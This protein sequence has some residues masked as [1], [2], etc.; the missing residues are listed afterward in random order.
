MSDER[1]FPVSKERVQT[2][3]DELR[4]KKIA[5]VGDFHL[6]VYWEADM[7][8]ARLSRETPHFARPVVRERYEGGV[9]GV[10][11][12]NLCALGVGTVYAFGAAG[13]DWRGAVLK[14]RLQDQG[15]DLSFFKTVPRRVTPAYIKPMLHGYESV[16]E[17]P[18]LDFQDPHDL[19]VNVERTLL[20]ELQECAG[21][22]DGIV[23]IDQV[24]ARTGGM[25]TAAVRE[26][27]SAVSLQNEDLPVLADSRSRIGL[28]RDVSVKA[29]RL[30]IARDLGASEP[31]DRQDAASMAM[32]L[33]KKTGGDV[34][35]SMGAEGMVF[36]SGEKAGYVPA[37]P[38]EGEVDIVG[39][40]DSASAGLVS[41]L[42]SGAALHEACFFANLVA[43]VTVRKIGMTGTASARELLAVF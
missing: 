30:E 27:L 24:E 35:V 10:I 19:P 12:A 43:S 4:G 26:T 42:A 23:V 31:H 14:E 17:D 2:V 32:Q 1:T 34:F 9:G 11:T 25:V 20:H 37:V 5:V 29:N 33:G 39:A 28:F 7:R 41:A 3:L 15:V 13:G 36:S 6:D 22:L 18:R 16:Q 21:G 38:V 8:R 40:G